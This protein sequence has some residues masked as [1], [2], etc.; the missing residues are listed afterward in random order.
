[1][2][3]G[4]LE[5]GNVILERC[6][7]WNDQGRQNA[8]IPDEV[9]MGLED[10]FEKHHVLLGGRST[11]REERFQNVTKELILIF[12]KE[13]DFTKHY[14]N[15]HLIHYNL[16]GVKPDDIS[17]LEDKLLE[18]FDTLTELYDKM[19]K[20]KIQRSNFVH[21]QYVLFQLLSWHKHP[22]RRENFSILKT[23]ERQAFHDDICKE[24]FQEL[25]WNHTPCF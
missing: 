14:E 2:D 22:C 3:A 5:Q 4:C 18:D 8:H 25:G 20:N 19:F 23:I 12:L 7:C 13:L 16:T 24:M 6:I 17:Y 9:Y 15:V 10:Q 1:M 21:C 11:P